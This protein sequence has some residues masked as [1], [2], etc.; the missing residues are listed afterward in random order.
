MS[1]TQELVSNKIHHREV[2]YDWLNNYISTDGM[3]KAYGVSRAEIVNAINSGR[4]QDRQ[5]RARNRA[6]KK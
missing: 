5:I 6:R 1:L 3:A 4:R 2:Y